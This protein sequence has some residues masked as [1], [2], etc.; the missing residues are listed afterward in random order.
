MTYLVSQQ[1]TSEGYPYKDKLTETL[2]LHEIIRQSI[3]AQTSA[4]S[5]LAEKFGLYGNNYRKES[6]CNVVLQ[7]E[8]C[9]NQ[10]EKVRFCNLPTDEDGNDGL[11]IRRLSLQLR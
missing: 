7:Y 11:K 4:G 10:W 1:S 3:L 9:L 6:Y 8:A 2:E 5:S